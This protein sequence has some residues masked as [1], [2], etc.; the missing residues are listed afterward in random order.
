MDR[1]GLTENTLVIFSS[2][3]GPAAAAKEL[4]LYYDS[5]TGAGYDR[6]AS[7]GITGGRKGYKAS[8]FEGGIGVPFIARWPGKVPAG[9]VDDVSLMSAVDLLPTFCEIAG[10]ELP[11]DYQPDG[12]SQVA[13]LKGNQYPS[14]TKPLFWKY[15]SRW[16]APNSKPD[17]WVSYAVVD[18][19][20]K[21]VTNDDLSH[22]EL[23]DI[24]K[25]VYEKNDLKAQHPETVKQLLVKLEAWQRSLPAKP[26]GNVFS[27]ERD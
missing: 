24:A 23:Y 21:L 5:A 17:H 20:W 3:N 8:L 10:V 7:K 2:D 11:S 4:S 13:T 27:A 6:G 22:V 25:D 26:E 12:V 9:K 14:R 1:L 16:P 19:T 15:P 18:Q